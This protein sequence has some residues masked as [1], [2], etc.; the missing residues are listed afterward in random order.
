M[1][2]RAV[3]FDAAGTLMEL[4]ESVGETYSRFAARQQVVLPPDRLQDAF[5]RYLNSAETVPHLGSS[6]EEV[7]ATERSWWRDIVRGT[8]RAADGTAR[9][10]N[11]E[12][13]FTE[14]YA[15][16]GSGDAW[17]LRPGASLGLLALRRAEIRVGVVS[18]FDHRLPQILRDL[19]ILE[20]LETVAL[21]SNSGERKPAPGAF[22]AALA[23]LG[24]AAEETLYVG[25]DPQLDLEAA[26]RCG[27]RAVSIEQ[28]QSW[29][30][31]PATLNAIATLGHGGSCETNGPA[32]LPEKGS[33]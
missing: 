26:R 23:R 24:V 25:D 13:F 15:Y 9:F 29:E 27:L 4:R 21:P 30:N 19:Q 14:L 17:S 33:A 32:P 18:N 16:Y 3:L 20:L 12:D 11:F 2:L 7:R 31:L 28:I 6:V 5:E 1:N 22:R 8:F 10:Q